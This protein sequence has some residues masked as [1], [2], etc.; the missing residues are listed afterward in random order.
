MDH[1]LPQ[2]VIAPVLN[3]LADATVEEAFREGGS[4]D[5]AFEDLVG[6]VVLIAFD[7][8]FAHQLHHPDWML[9]LARLRLLASDDRLGDLAKLDQVVH[10]HPLGPSVD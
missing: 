9:R 8:L 4:S 2:D 10:D 7:T 5:E 3:A 1:P 6:T